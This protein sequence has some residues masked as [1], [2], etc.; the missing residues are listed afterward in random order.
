MKAVLLDNVLGRDVGQSGERVVHPDSDT[1]DGTVGEDENGSDG[2]DESSDLGFYPLPVGLVLLG[3]AGLGEPRCIE[4][5]NLEKK[6]HLLTRLKGA[7]AYHYSVPAL[8]CVNVY[9][10]GPTLVAG[11]ALIVCA[12]ENVEV[13]VINVFAEKDIGN[14]L[15]N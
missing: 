6:L 4:D 10:L 15:H 7:V 2:V 9:A 13:V 8:K 11:I 14:E 12:V 5:A 3:I 1:R